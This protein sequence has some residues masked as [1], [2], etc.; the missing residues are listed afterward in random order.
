M[1]YGMVWYGMVWYGMVWYGVVWYGMVWYDMVW[2]GV[3]L[4]S[5]AWHGMAWLDAIGLSR[6]S[7]SSGGSWYDFPC[8]QE[9]GLVRCGRRGS[10][11]HSGA[12]R[13]P[14]DVR[15]VGRR[16]QEL[17]PAAVQYG[18]FLRRGSGA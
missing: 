3:A 14:E 1:W 18:V 4:H 13:A 2:H 6:R 7:C 8:R 15:L 5:M 17:S 16:R 11:A 10:S 9:Q 12:W